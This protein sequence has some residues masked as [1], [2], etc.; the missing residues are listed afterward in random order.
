[1]QFEYINYG[2]SLI[3]GLKK[4]SSILYIFSDYPLK[5]SQRKESKRN[6]F[7]PDPV[8]LTIDE[9]KNR[10]FRSD[11]IIL[12]EAKRFISLYNYMKKDFLDININNYFESI[13]FSDKFFKY[14]AEL[15]KSLS[16]ENI[17]LEEW[18][19]K[20]FEI[21][22]KFKAKYDVH[23]DEKNYIPKDWIHSLE[24]LDLSPFKKY[25]K[26]IFIDIVNFTLLDKLMISKLEEFLEVVI[27]VQGEIGVFD[28]ENL[29]LKDVY[30]PKVQKNE[31][32]ILEVQDELELMGNL[33]DVMKVKNN[34][35][36]IFS[37]EADENEYS[38]IFPNNFMRG[39]FYT[40]N[41]TKFFKFLQ[42]LNELVSSLEPRMDNLIPVNKFLKG[43]RTSEMQEYYEIEREDMEYIYNQVDWDYKYIG[44]EKNDKITKI[45][46]DILK[47]YKVKNIDTFIDYFNE[48]LSLNMFREKI[49]LDFYDKLQEYMGYA[50]TTEIMLEEKDLNSC[51]R[52]GGEILKFLLQYFNGVEIIR[53]D[54]S[55]GKYL[56][57]PMQNCK[58]VQ[59]RESIFINLSTRYLPKLKK[60]YIYLTEKQKKD[61]GFSYYEKERK[62]EKYRFYQNILKNKFNTIMYIKNENTGE[63]VSPILSE[64][65]NKYKVSKLEKVVYSED[66]LERLLALKSNSI[67]EFKNS[68]LLKEKIDFKN[69]ELSLGAYD[70][71]D[72]EKCEY[73]FYLKKL[74]S[75]SSFEK[76]DSLGLSLKFLGTYIH[77]VFEKLTDKMW[78]KILNVSDYSITHEEVE[79]L[80][81]SSFRYNR[82]KIPLYL[83]NY[84]IQILIPRFTKNILKFYKEI[85]N[86]YIETAVKRIESEK[87][88]KK[89]PILKGEVEVTLSGRVDLVIETSKN[90]HL[91]DFKTG[92]KIDKQLDFYTIMLYGDETR[93]DKSF[94][95]AFEGKFE[96]QEK[97]KL[98]KELLKE[99]LIEFFK[100]KTY[101]LSHKKN[102][103]LYCEYEN[104][105]RR[106]F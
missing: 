36:N 43:I 44:E 32:S 100:E 53:N 31:I 75:V 40:I 24:N 23:L 76:E 34:M 72:L 2:G 101:I 37:P 84:F 98:T 55:E 28:E 85:E 105:C 41:D 71:E 80:L 51:F 61:N 54:K 90:N 95:N 67:L 66:I 57:K 89:E 7:E 39:S 99:R 20:Y 62:E 14:Y 74:Y 25:K 10:A 6:I 63:G 3:Q 93:A 11:R 68:N 38:K 103:C 81:L 9:F 30:L 48:L 16:S 77:E 96:N 58:V 22:H 5:N 49:Y 29:E 70:Y 86:L 45:Y 26:I 91:I 19:K 97:S 8:Y 46:L 104:I 12:S 52:N 59:S 78:K 87:N 102:G 4:D 94:Y 27:R 33:L 15:N 79:E 1:M 17:E 60:D 13:E 50:K 82:K 35:T 65:L 92:S 106:E 42:S 69:N 21:F 56:I 47:I 18:Q 88:S 83:D 64:I 73:K